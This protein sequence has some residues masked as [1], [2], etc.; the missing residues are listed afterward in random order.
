MTRSSQV[1]GRS[2]A[3]LGVM[4]GLG[5]VCNPAGKFDLSLVFINASASNE[6]RQAGSACSPSGLGGSAGKPRRC[7]GGRLATSKMIVSAIAAGPER[8]SKLEWGI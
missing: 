2:A 5:L 4:E 8:L 1:S 3:R 6:S 7:L